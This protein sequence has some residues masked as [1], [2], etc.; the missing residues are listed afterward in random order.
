MV[1]FPTV[2]FCL[3]INWNFRAFLLGLLISIK[4]FYVYGQPSAAIFQQLS[5]E[6]G[7]PNPYTS[8]AVQ[9]KSGFI[10]IGTFSGLV[11]YDGYRLK[12]FS[13]QQGNP[14]SLSSNYI[15]TVFTS[16]NGTIWVGTTFGLNRFDLQTGQFERFYLTKW[17]E[18]CNNVRVIAED[19]QG[20]LWLGTSVGVFILNPQ[21]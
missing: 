14:S 5:T 13:H 4:F 19:P 11:R 7:L 6:Q 17:G 9:D 3:S 16:R 20:F 10:W 1:Y 2:H 21:T 15:R 8:A 12:T 18:K